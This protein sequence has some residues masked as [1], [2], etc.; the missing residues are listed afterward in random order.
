MPRP[1]APPAATTTTR[2]SFDQGCAR[3]PPS[4]P[5]V[6]ANTNLVASRYPLHYTPCM[7]HPR[8]ETPVHTHL[9]RWPERLHRDV[10]RI[11]TAEGVNL[12]T[13]ERLW[14]AAMVELYDAGD[15]VA[16]LDGV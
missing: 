15:G 16:S 14:I 4:L 10:E 5:T 7:A 12:A 13:L 3:T 8:L 11:A 1:R 6:I 2:P 9:S